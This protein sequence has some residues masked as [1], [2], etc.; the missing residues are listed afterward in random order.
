M[1]K[2]FFGRMQNMLRYCGKWKMYPMSKWTFYDK[3]RN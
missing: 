3:W 1:C 2:M